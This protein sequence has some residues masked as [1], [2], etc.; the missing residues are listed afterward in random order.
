[1]KNLFFIACCA[2]IGLNI[3]GCSKGNPKNTDLTG[4]KYR[5]LIVGRWQM[6]ADT[7]LLTSNGVVV[8]DSQTGPTDEFYEFSADGSA[9]QYFGTTLQAKITYG[10]DSKSLTL[11][12]P[13]VTN[14]GVTVADAYSLEEPIKMLT[15]TDLILHHDLTFEIDVNGV[16]Q[17]SRSKQTLH[18]KKR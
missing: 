5:K 10:I 2:L 1:M 16:K 3:L 15:E 13:A 7:T 6:F 9:S 18:F 12:F 11:H 14:N 4:D 8:E 17:K